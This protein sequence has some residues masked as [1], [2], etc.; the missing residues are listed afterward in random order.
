MPNLKGAV[1][2]VLELIIHLTPLFII[3][4]V[5]CYPCYFVFLAVEDVANAVAFLLSDKS[6]MITG[7]ALAVDGGMLVA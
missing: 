2:E 7:T 1:V 4:H 3:E 5:F 6:D